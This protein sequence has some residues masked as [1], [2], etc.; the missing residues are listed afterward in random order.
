MFIF[1]NCAI[2]IDI[3]AYCKQWYWRWQCI[4]SST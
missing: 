1:F 2:L 3:V 4:V